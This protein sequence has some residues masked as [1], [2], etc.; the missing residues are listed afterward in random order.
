MEEKQRE[1]FSEREMRR[2]ERDDGINRM[3][4]LRQEGKQAGSR[5][6]LVDEQSTCKV[7]TFTFRLLPLADCIEIPD[8]RPHLHVCCQESYPVAP[9][10]IST[11]L[12]YQTVFS[13]PR[14]SRQRRTC[15]CTPTSHP[16]LQISLLMP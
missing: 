1:G 7:C 13:H 8:D 2:R 12:P 16:M 14:G 9:I 6:A 5:Q 10:P 4:G 3:E 11:S 15:S